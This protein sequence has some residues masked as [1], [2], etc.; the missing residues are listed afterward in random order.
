MSNIT[1]EG[2]VTTDVELHHLLA[3]LKEYPDK[4]ENLADQ[5]SKW[6][7]YIGVGEAVREWYAKPVNKFDLQRVRAWSK[8][9]QELYNLGNTIDPECTNIVVQT[10]L[11]LR[12]I[13]LDRAIKRLDDIIQDC[14]LQHVESP[15]EP[16]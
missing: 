5:L 2:T 4:A 10:E 11:R 14:F 1:A 13:E 7:S 15:S 3:L 16:C 6:S 8:K 12:L 9:L